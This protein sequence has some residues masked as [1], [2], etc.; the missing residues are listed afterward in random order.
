MTREPPVD[1]PAKGADAAP[2]VPAKTTR[3]LILDEAVVCFAT[4]GYEG[5]S[6][7]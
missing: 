1:G 2:A 3:E 6:R 4:T 7:S 5:T